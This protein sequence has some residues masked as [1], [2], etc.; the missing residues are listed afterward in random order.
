MLDPLTECHQQTHY[1]EKARHAPW[2]TLNRNMAALH[3][4]GNSSDWATGCSQH[5]CLSVVLFALWVFLCLHKCTHTLTHTQTYMYIDVHTHID[6]PSLICTLTHIETN[7]HAYS[8]TH[9]ETH[10]HTMHILCVRSILASG[11]LRAKCSS[12]LYFFSQEVTS[13]NSK[14]FWH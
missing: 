9:T 14:C 11:C 4:L 10:S 2:G 3:V 6:M 8:H 13:Q 7:T 1:L 12:F 5:P